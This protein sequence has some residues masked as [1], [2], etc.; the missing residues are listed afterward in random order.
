MKILEINIIAFFIGKIYEYY[1]IIDEIINQT[2]F[3][4]SNSD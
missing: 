3:L 4:Y 2:D 1:S